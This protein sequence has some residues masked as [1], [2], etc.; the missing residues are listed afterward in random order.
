LI[1]ARPHTLLRAGHAKIDQ[2]IA[3]RPVLTDT[4]K[5]KFMIGGHPA[6]YVT[7]QILNSNA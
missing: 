5:C 1:R 3:G 7:C 4:L 2:H 6:R